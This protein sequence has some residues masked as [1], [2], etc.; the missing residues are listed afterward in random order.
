MR[1]AYKRGRTIDEHINEQMKDAAFKKAWH[2]L[3]AEFALMESMI[4]AREKAGITQA[5]LAK[6][7]GTKQ[8]AISRL[9]RS[10]FKKASVETL[11]KIA[12]ALDATLVIKLQA[13]R[14]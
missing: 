1:T 8:S 5:E 9:E 12:H 14:G 7:I 6:R 4:K 11:S 10:G 3:D 13:K 2:D